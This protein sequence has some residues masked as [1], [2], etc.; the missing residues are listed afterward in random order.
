MID[1]LGFRIAAWLREHLTDR[2]IM[3]V[4]HALGALSFAFAVGGVAGAFWL[5]WNVVH[6]DVLATRWA[7]AALLVLAVLRIETRTEVRRG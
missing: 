1:R 4:A 2:A 6:G 7:I 3:W 5:A